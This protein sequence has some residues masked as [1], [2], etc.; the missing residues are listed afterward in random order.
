MLSDLKNDSSDISEYLQEKY[1]D[2]KTEAIK[3]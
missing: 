2:Q 1:S 3:I